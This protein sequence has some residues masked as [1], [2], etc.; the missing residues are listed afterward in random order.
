M[1]SL[2]P[3]DISAPTRAA[4][5]WQLFKLESRSDERVQ[6]FD[7]ARNQIADRVAQEKQRVE[8]QKYLDRQRTQAIITW[9]NDDL[10][11]AYEQALAKRKAS[12]GAARE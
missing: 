1:D 9:R 12:A 4:K 11:K 2:K 8:L 6:T 7:V 3:G 5:G 10:K